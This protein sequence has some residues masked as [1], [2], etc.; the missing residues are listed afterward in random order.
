MSED[1]VEGMD[2]RPT[3]PRLRGGTR[4]PG[5]SQDPLD[6]RADV[7]EN[8]DRYEP[9]AGED[10]YDVNDG[11]AEDG[12]DHQATNDHYSEHPD[13]PPG[14]R[15]PREATVFDRSSTGEPD[16]ESSVSSQH[17][18]RTNSTSWDQRAQEAEDQDRGSIPCGTIIQQN[19]E[20]RRFIARGGMGEVYE[21]TNIHLNE[22]LAIKV[23]LPQW[24]SKS[25]V[26]Q[27]FRI[28]A[29]TLNKLQHDALVQYRNFIYDVHHDIYC[30]V[31]EF[32]DGDNL[33]DVLGR[34]RPSP[35][36]LRALLIRLALGLQ[37]AHDHGAIHRD[38]SPDN[39]ILK[40]G[41]LDRA[42]IIDFGIAKDMNAGGKSIFGDGFVGKLAY[43][44]PEQLGLFDGRMGEWSDVYCLALVIK[45]IA[46]GEDLRLGATPADAVRTRQ[47][48]IDLS[49]VSEELRGVLEAMLKAD[50]A[51]R[52]QSMG[53]VL[54]ALEGAAP[55]VVVKETHD[56]D[57]KPPP[58]RSLLLIA[59]CALAG[60]LL[61]GALIYAIG[62]DHEP[63]TATGTGA[64]GPRIDRVA[65]ARQTLIAAAPNI[66]CSWLREVG[67]TERDGQ[68]SL[69]L[70]GVA[71]DPAEVQ[72]QLISRL[73]VSG[74][75]NSNIDLSEI[76]EIDRS[77][78][79]ILNAFRERQTFT[80]R[81]LEAQQQQQYELSLP[82]P[83]AVQVAGMPAAR[84]VFNLFDLASVEDYAILSIAPTGVVEPMIPSRQAKEQSY[85][86]LFTQTEGGERFSPWIYNDL[87]WTGFILVTGKGPFEAAVLAPP[88]GQRDADWRSRFREV[89]TRQG[90]QIEMVWVET[91]DQTPD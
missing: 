34:I 63:V 47:K 73:R 11:S 16:A 19:Y 37:V 74:L 49:E 27:Q 82:P 58:W 38:I 75:A 59:G 22:R 54:T 5:A 90:W 12:Y 62:T 36:E 3:R 29:G 78:C 60:V 26:V 35:E 65:T 32:I 87:G 30:L 51:K 46:R 15:R 69:T 61:L 45:A 28:E 40:D 68:V 14:T 67:I 85:A 44:A 24:A 88:L 48:G 4:Y 72:R 2:P 86:Y 52:L 83:E 70:A 71:L 91:V 20:I 84:A 53:D 8:K 25:Q 1:D 7:A 80:G 9:F 18:S 76:A 31:T 23:I 50:P 79:E 55:P 39:I 42:K 33:A 64:S 21:A 13:T 56:N 41:R 81:R 17:T 57:G 43:A 10:P 77:Y 89:A 66:D 6:D